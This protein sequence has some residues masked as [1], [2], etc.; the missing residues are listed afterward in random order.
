[1][2]QLHCNI[3]LVMIKDCFKLNCSEFTGNLSLAL[4]PHPPPATPSLADSLDATSE[5]AETESNVNRNANPLLL[6]SPSVGSPHAAKPA[7]LPT[8]PNSLIQ[9]GMN[10]PQR[11]HKVQPIMKTCHYTKSDTS[12]GKLA[13]HLAPH[14]EAPK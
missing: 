3:E 14:F 13:S 5:I 6:P 7:I 10:A 8:S 1:M 12:S 9:P 11:H 4:D 2:V